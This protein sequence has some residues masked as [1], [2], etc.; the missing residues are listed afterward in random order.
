MTKLYCVDVVDY[1]SEKEE[2]QSTD[3]EYSTAD[4]VTDCALA[5]VEEG[6]AFRV[7]RPTFARMARHSSRVHANSLPS[8]LPV[9][10][11]G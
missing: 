11:L 6:Y 8:A 10:A 7:P 9:E 2:K 5:E 4:F 3:Q 1:C